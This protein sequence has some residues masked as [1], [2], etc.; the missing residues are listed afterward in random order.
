[1]KNAIIL[2]AV[3]AVLVLG[4]ANTSVCSAE[5]YT[6]NIMLTGWWG[7]SH[8]IIAKFSTD[9]E[10]NPG[11]WEGMNWEG[12]G[13]NIYAYFPKFPPGNEQIG[14]GDL[15]VDYQDVSVD[16]WRITE[17][18]HPVAIL[19]YGLGPGP[20]QLEKDARNLGSGPTIPFW[21]NDYRAPY[22]PT[23]SPPDAGKDVN[24]VR[25]S[26]LPIEP[27]I[28]NINAAGLGITATWDDGDSGHF[29]CE[30]MAYHDA[31]YQDLHGDESDDYWCI[32]AG[33][34]HLWSTLSLDQAGEA[35]D[36]TLRTTIDHVDSVLPEPATVS[37]LALG[38]LM[39]LRRRRE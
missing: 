33:F 31:W 25:H 32:A 12:R 34:T 16:F 4:F 9:T 20:W 3:A 5:G 13:Y 7:L 37:L 28:D 30:F 19:S 17:E 35:A 38:G 6:K 23:P 24:Y 2:L 39:L 27:I 22:Q 26:S 15:E 1:M 8:E 36:I 18:I 29:L 21:S 14:E 10:L 11:G